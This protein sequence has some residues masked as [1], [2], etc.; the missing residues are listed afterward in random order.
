MKKVNKYWLVVILA[1]VFILNINLNAQAV[2]SVELGDAVNIQAVVCGVFKSDRSLWVYPPG[3]PENVIEFD[4]SEDV[5]NYEQLDVGDTVNYPAGQSHQQAIAGPHDG[6][7]NILPAGVYF[8]VRHR[9]AAD[10]G[11][12]IDTLGFD[13]EV[14]HGFDV[15]IFVNHQTGD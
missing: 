7:D 1:A 4:V 15:A 8:V 9:K 5:K 11:D 2:A 3:N 13:A 12:Q 10:K 6:D 14:L